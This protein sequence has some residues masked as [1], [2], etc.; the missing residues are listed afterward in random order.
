MPA[1]DPQAVVS[2]LAAQA[3][4]TKAPQF[5]LIYASL[6]DGKSWCGD[7]RASEPLI[8]QKFRQDEQP[9]RLTIHYAGDRETSV[10]PIAKTRDRALEFASG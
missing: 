6:V 8:N 5:L 1:I 7:C 10:Q 2:T 4:A 3:S 9:P